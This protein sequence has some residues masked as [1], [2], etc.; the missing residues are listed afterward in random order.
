MSP[1]SA[2]PQEKPPQV[3]KQ[4]LFDAETIAHRIQELAA[5]IECDYRGGIFSW[6]VY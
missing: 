3:A 4:I 2:D 5:E 6:S 1:V